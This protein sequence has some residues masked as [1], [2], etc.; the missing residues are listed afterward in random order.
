MR[1]PSEMDDGGAL[2]LNAISLLHE[3]ETRA[4]DRELQRGGR[5]FAT[6]GQDWDRTHRCVAKLHGDGM[7]ASSGV[8]TD[9]KEAK[10]KSYR[11]P[12]KRVREKSPKSA[13]LNGH[14]SGK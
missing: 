3:W 11:A 10:P 13:I 9:R 2:S 8:Q 12:E 14:S 5:A 6:V 1:A 7:E 4:T